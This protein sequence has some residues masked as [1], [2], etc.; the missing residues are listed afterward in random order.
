MVKTEK[1]C[2]RGR[3]PVGLIQEGARLCITLHSCF[4]DAVSQSLFISFKN[5][6]PTLEAC[7][8]LGLDTRIICKNV[9]EKPTDAL[10]KQLNNKLEF[11]RNYEKL[12]PYCDYCEEMFYLKKLINSREFKSVGQP[13]FHGPAGVKVGLA[14]P[15]LL[16]HGKDENYYSRSCS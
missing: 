3:R 8:I 9:N 4:R 6:C 2:L 7:K 10:V 1:F 5:F 11:A 12:R 14:Y 16:G 13:T 15:G